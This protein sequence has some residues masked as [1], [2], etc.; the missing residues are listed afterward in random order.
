MKS[1]DVKENTYIDFKKEINNRDPKFKVGDQY[2]RVYLLKDVCQIGQKKYL[3]LRELKILCH[4]HMLL[5]I[6]MGKKLLVLFM[7]MNYKVQINRNLE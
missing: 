1:V 5:M 4:G 6:S 3:L 7:K 2:T